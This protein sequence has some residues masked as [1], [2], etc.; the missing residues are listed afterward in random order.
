MRH[1]LK[2]YYHWLLSQLSPRMAI[3]L[4]HLVGHGTLPRLDNPTTFSEK[5]QFRKLHDRDERLPRMADKLLVK[6]YVEEKLGPA[7]VIPTLW[8]GCSLPPLAERTWPAP[9]VIKANN[10]SATNYFVHHETDKDW[11]KI[12]ALCERWMAAPNRAPLGEWAYLQITPQ[13]L[14]EPFVGIG[15]SL[16]WDYKLMVFNGRVEFIQVDT[17]RATV[18]RR[19][20]F[21]RDWV[22][23]PFE[24]RRP[25]EAGNIPRPVSLKAMIDG[26][27][28]LAADFSFVRV[29]MYEVGD[30][31]LFGEMTFYPGSG[32][33]RF[34][35]NSYDEQWGRLWPQLP[36]RRERSPIKRDPEAVQ[37]P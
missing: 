14:I 36:S 1:L 26:A 11:R 18:H 9:F 22:R 32:M 10:G 17:G 12:E 29:D 33:S 7:W 35:P 28:A 8:H 24:L 16:P 3:S 19:T 20:F 13:I 31:P 21:D 27:E 5:I 37:A 6:A 25:A 15:N 2:H 30:R 4:S 23:Q 34:R